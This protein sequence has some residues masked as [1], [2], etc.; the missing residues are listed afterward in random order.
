MKQLNTKLMHP[1]EQ[2]CI[3]ISR[4]YRGGM[5]TTSGGNLSIMDDNGDMWITP[6]GIDKG[7]LKPS[8]I[9]CVKADGTVIGPHKPSSEY[10]FHRAL[11]R[12]RPKMRSVIHAHPAGLVT[13]SIVHQIPN[14]SILPQ[15]HA[16]CGP[17]GFAPYD[18]P[19][20][21]ALGEKI[22]EEFRKHPEYKAVIMENHG[23]VLAGE[24]IADAYQRFE[25]LEL[26]ARTIINAKT[27]GEPIYLTDDQL[28]FH[29]SRLP[30][31]FQHFMNVTHPSEERAI[32][33]EICRMVRR[34]CDQKLMSSSYGTVSMRWK[35]NDFLI[36][37]TGVQRWDIDEEDIVQIK[38]GMAEAG[39]LPS[40][41]AAL[42][43]EIYRRNPKV[44]AIVL[45]QCPSL[46]GFCTTDTKF[47]VRTI[48]ESWIFLQDVPKFE[49]GS[50]YTKP[51][52]VAEVFKSR[53]CAMLAND[54]VVVASDSLIN[55]FD[56]LEVA[57]FAAKSLILAKPVGDL[58]PITDKEVEDLR[59]AF[60]VGE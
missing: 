42:H 14:T 44:N 23:V 57:E 37:P 5:T 29:E 51:S 50:Q 12:M 49:F 55:A 54:S 45:T 21:E 36:T 17:I 47:D 35:D 16:V 31:D 19:G 11:Y 15:V 7:S 1:A 22:A 40:H 39:K 18:V 53:P 13:F 60:H 58:H 33:T 26:C 28:N 20:S 30:N 34:A 48:P 24:D 8:D 56:R 3:I 46:M 25:T 32:R 9:M 10:P 41:S 2:I 43:Y 59:V 27:L 6:S 4:I 38:D 52:E